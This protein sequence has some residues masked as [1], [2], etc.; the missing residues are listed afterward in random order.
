MFRNLRTGLRTFTLIP[1][2][3][4]ESINS[5]IRQHV[6]TLR[7]RRTAKNGLDVDVFSCKCF[8]FG[9]SVMVVMIYDILAARQSNVNPSLLLNPAMLLH[10]RLDD[11]EHK[12]DWNLRILPSI[13]NQ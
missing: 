12:E 11:G 4:N 7:C 2:E 10:K 9:V 13:L 5:F 6:T 3:G 1:A 8:Q